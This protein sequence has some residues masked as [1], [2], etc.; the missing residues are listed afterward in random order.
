MKIQ[1]SFRLLPNWLLEGS[2]LLS[3][4][5]HVV[6][7]LSRRDAELLPLVVAAHALRVLVQAGEAAALVVRL[8]ALHLDDLGAREHVLKLDRRSVL[9]LVLDDFL[10]VLLD[11]VAH[12]KSLVVLISFVSVLV[13]P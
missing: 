8:D 5:H 10:D 4:P 7:T 2:L 13:T 11:S 9:L 1:T 3:V 6:A 12:V